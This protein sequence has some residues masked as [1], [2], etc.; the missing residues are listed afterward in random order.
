MSEDTK[1][2]MCPSCRTEHKAS[3]KRC[4]CGYEWKYLDQQ[5]Y[6][7]T[8]SGRCAWESD[9]TRCANAGA[10]A[11][12]TIGSDRWY[13]SGHYGC[14][15]A[16]LGHEI[17][18][19]SIKQHGHNPDL[20]I[21]ARRSRSLAIA[22]TAVPEYLRGWTVDEYRQNARHLLST[23]GK[24][25]PEGRLGWAYKIMDMIERGEAVPHI[26]VQ[27]AKQRRAESNG[28]AN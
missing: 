14:T 20:S 22:E 9:G 18:L 4:G 24:P 25:K 2:K 27:I 13:C 16:V 28:E 15:S 12:G 8:Q 23:V 6:G 5:K 1:Y 19:A 10:L 21:E 17:V 11:E 26:T 7:E 3:V